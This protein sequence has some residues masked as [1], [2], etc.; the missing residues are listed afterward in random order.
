[1]RGGR[2]WMLLIAL[3]VVVIVNL[4]QFR[5]IDAFH[6]GVGYAALG[7][8]PTSDIMTEG[9][10][11]ERIDASY[12]MFLDVGEASPRSHLVASSRGILPVADLRDLALSFGD[13]S[14]MT[15]REFDDTTAPPAADLIAQGGAVAAEGVVKADDRYDVPW[16]LITG[17]CGAASG[18]SPGRQLVI[19][20]WGAGPT[21]AIGVV[22]SCLLPAGFSGQ[23]A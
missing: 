10:A 7:R 1:M 4:V 22:E 16:Q 21:L 5:S 2:R 19:V 6:G 18:S 12:G 11:N 14:T 17:E 9:R 13:A 8:L 15:V 23:A 3:A 20:R